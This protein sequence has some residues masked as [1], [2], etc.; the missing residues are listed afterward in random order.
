MATPLARLLPLLL[1]LPPPLRE[2]LS[3]SK[4][5]AKQDAATGVLHPIVLFPG[6]SCP[7]VEARLTEAYRPSVPRCGA[8][9]GK[10]WFGLWENASDIP[11]HD[12]IEC[13]K[14]QMS[15]V[16]D[17]AVNDYRNPPG[18]QTRIPNFGSAS[19]FSDKK[20]LGR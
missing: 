11:A 13:F 9:T 15:L 12:Y 7:Y 6:A 3:A 1:L 5:G 10:P 16:Y 14:E 20:P 17:P 18:V 19:G 4:H 8:M 2:Y